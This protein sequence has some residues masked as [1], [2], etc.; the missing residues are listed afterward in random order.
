MVACACTPD[1][2]KRP[3]RAGSPA[4]TSGAGSPDASPPDTPRSVLLAKSAV[5]SLLTYTIAALFA[6]FS[7][8][9]NVYCYCLTA[10]TLL[11]AWLGMYCPDKLLSM[12]AYSV[13]PGPVFEIVKTR[14]ILAGAG[15]GHVSVGGLS[16][17]Q[18]ALA[19]SACLDVAASLNSAPPWRTCRSSLPEGPRSSLLHV[20]QVLCCRTL[21]CRLPGKPP[22]G[23]SVVQVRFCHRGVSG[24]AWL[25]PQACRL[26]KHQLVLQA[27]NKSGPAGACHSGEHATSLGLL[28]SAHAALALLILIVHQASVVNRRGGG[29]TPAAGPA[30]AS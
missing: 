11:A 15:R 18:L 25:K 2:D 21:G 19:C 29:T 27:R 24:F 3:A 14:G 10:G 22:D 4:G 9:P 7:T 20:L 8:D 28:C 13:L 17:C 23:A 5:C 26:G 1:N 6:R 16:G 12:L 30:T